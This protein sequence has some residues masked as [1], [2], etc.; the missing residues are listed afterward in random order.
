MTE[1]QLNKNLPLR[2]INVSGDTQQRALSL[3][4]I[5]NYLGLMKD[6][7]EFPPVEVVFDGK[8]Y[9][10]WDGFHRLECAKRLKKDTIEA[11]VQS[12][13]IRRAK[14]LSFSANNKH[15]LQRNLG[16]VE[17]IIRQIFVD[18]QWKRQ[19]VA[20][21]AKHVGCSRQSV[22]NI[23]RKIDSEETTISSKHDAKRRRKPKEPAYEPTA[24]LRKT[25]SVY[26]NSEILEQVDYSIEGDFETLVVKNAEAIFGSK[27]IYIDAKRKLPT[28]ALGGTIPDGFLIDLSD[29][30]NPQFYLIEI[31]LQSHDFRSHIFPQISKFIDF[32][33]YSKHRLE[34]TETLYP[35]FQEGTVLAEKIRNSI[36]SKEVYKFLKDTICQ[37]Q[38]ILIVIEGAKSE[39]ENIGNTYT[40]TWRTMVGVH[41]IKHFQKGENNIITVEPSFQNE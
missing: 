22:Y 7:E 33:G 17:H 39:L 5:E 13:D 11:N 9:W 36:G 19:P 23:K 27:S 16:D 20:K 4:T 2:L 12:G 29:L 32:Y 37:S 35:L 41:I 30:D 28:K 24:R 40:D 25:I 18:A 34:L 8:D 3:E 15:G 21:I 31:E 1:K 14:W 26:L 38:N 10:L 6:G